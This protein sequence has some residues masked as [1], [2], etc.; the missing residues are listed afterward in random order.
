MCGSNSPHWNGML[1]GGLSQKI[2]VGYSVR[3]AKGY[4][5]GGEDLSTPA[6]TTDDRNGAHG[7]MSQVG[8]LRQLMIGGGVTAIAAKRTLIFLWLMTRE[9]SDTDL[10]GAC[11]LGPITR[12]IVLPSTEQE[13]TI[14]TSAGTPRSEPCNKSKRVGQK[15]PLKVNDIWAIRVRL[16]MQRRVR[17]LAL[18][19]LGIDSKLRR[20]KPTLIYRRTKNLRA[21]QLLLGHTKLESMVRYLGIE[22]HDALEIA[23]QTEI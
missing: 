12:T 9:G 16:Q 15:A 1:R 11:S 19:D 4:C 21:V 20:T 6:A 13:D 5:G 18:F 22:V 7:A 23:E 10:P 14:D 2:F 8:R 3:A 17:D